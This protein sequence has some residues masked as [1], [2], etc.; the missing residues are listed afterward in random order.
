MVDLRVDQHSDR[1]VA[2]TFERLA[3]YVVAEHT[4]DGTLQ[5]VVDL[6]G[7]AIGGAEAV[8]ISL[9]RKGSVVTAVS[10]KSKVLAIDD[11][12][13]QSGS[14]P[15]LQAMADGQ[16]QLVESLLTDGRW[17]EFTNKALYEGVLSIVAF[18]L[19]SNEEVFGAL[20]VYSPRER[21]FGEKSISVGEVFAA[22]ASVVLV[23]ATRYEAATQLSSQLEEALQSRAVI[24]QAKGILMEREK[25]SADEAFE[26]LKS[27]SQRS[28]IKVREL[29]QR[30]VHDAVQRAG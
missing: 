3:T 9:M 2:D 29:A 12:Q 7:S 19:R 28:N 26:Q 10:S 23:N 6:A 17:P 13:Y 5:L 24:D 15:C 1:V 30:I 21:A 27:I 25:I 8:G 11:L 18:P 20:N 4:V 16:M 14:G 22:R